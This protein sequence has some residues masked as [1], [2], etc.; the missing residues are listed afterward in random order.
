MQVFLVELI[1]NFEFGM[2]Q[3]ASNVIRVPSFVMVA[4]IKGQEEKGVQTPL[5]I[6]PAPLKEDF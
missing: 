6:K 2:T 5:K 3:E 4:M 1:N